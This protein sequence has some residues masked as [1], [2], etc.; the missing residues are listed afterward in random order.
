MNGANEFF[1]AMEPSDKKREQAISPTP[2]YRLASTLLLASCSPAEPAS[3][4]GYQIKN[5]SLNNI[6]NM[7]HR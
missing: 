3:S 6:E 7:P 4:W 1:L 2:V 5:S